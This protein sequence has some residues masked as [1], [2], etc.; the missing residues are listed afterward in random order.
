MV[1]FQN[2]TVLTDGSY[3]FL[4]EIPSKCEKGT[5]VTPSVDSSA[6][7]KIFVEMLDKI[8]IEHTRIEILNRKMSAR[9]HTKW[10]FYP[11]RGGNAYIFQPLGPSPSDSGVTST[12]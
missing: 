11:S 7:I 12:G 2:D 6:R 4:L 9:E 1:N 10:R 8:H 3:G 5:A